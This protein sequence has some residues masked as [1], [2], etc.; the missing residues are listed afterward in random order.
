MS[1]LTKYNAHSAGAVVQH[2]VQCIVIEIEDDS[3][4]FP[5]L[6]LE[7]RGTDATNAEVRNLPLSEAEIVLDSV[8]IHHQA[9]GIVQF[10]VRKLRFLGCGD[11]HF[12]GVPDG[13][14]GDIL[15][16]SVFPCGCSVNGQG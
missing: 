8:K 6:T 1:R 13:A 12:K 3:R 7:K 15:N 10:K 2:A 9:M 14:E 4:R 5:L 11:L 16:C